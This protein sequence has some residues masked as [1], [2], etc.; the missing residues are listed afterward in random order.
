MVRKY[1]MSH[2]F[3]FVQRNL[4]IF[5]FFLLLRLQLPFLSVPLNTNLLRT[6]DKNQYIAST[7]PPDFRQQR[8][9]HDH[10]ISLTPI[11]FQQGITAGQNSRMNDSVQPL[12]LLSGIEDGR[13]Q[14]PAVNSPIRAEN[15]ATERSADLLTDC[16]FVQNL[17]GNRIRINPP[18]TQPLKTPSGRTLT[19]SNPAQYPNNSKLIWRKT[20]NTPAPLFCQ[21]LVF[22]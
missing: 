9:I 18:A 13:R 14:L 4:K 20:H 10:R 6:I 22:S 1:I 21:Q 2:L 15:L 7:V 16:R 8:H 5:S 12:H 3:L 19:G 17:M 11:G